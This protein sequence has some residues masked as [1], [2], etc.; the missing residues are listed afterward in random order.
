MFILK[1]FNARHFEYSGKRCSLDDCALVSHSTTDMQALVDKFAKAAS[2]FSP[3]INIKKTEC[4]YQPPT[5]LTVAAST[6]INEQDQPLTM[7]C[8]RAVQSRPRNQSENG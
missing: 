4:L 6:L 8:V 3:K 2:Q 7:C 5:Y 1:R